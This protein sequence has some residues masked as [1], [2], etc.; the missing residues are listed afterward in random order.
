MDGAVL[1][2]EWLVL[3]E[4]LV[5]FPGNVICRGLDTP[6]AMLTLFDALATLPDPRNPQGRTHMLPAILGSA[7]S[8]L[9]D[10]RRHDIRTADQGKRL[11]ASN[12]TW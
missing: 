5:G 4:V 6:M 10:E 12:P 11:T 9:P 3:A 7:T 8:V 1:W 2:T